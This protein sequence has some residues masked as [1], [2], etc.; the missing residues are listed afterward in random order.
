VT[1]LFSSERTDGRYCLIDR[2]H[3]HGTYFGAREATILETRIAAHGFPQGMKLEADV[4]GVA[5]DFEKL[6]QD[7]DRVIAVVRP[8]VTC[9]NEKRLTNKGH[10]QV[11]TA[12]GADPLRACRR[13]QTGLLSAFS[14]P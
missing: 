7:F 1:T 4:V 2:Q 14:F 8:S 9:A 3:R 10:K 6:P 13:S 11:T 5:G 12:P